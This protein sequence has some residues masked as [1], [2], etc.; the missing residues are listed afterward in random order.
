MHSGFSALRRECPMELEIRTQIEVGED[1]AKD[2][3]RVVEV[4]SGLLD[5]FGG[6]F[7][8]G[9]WSIADV[10]YTPVATRFRTWGIALADY[11]DDGRCDKY[12]QKL[13]ETPEYLEW[14]TVALA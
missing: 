5:R 4:W 3:A 2:V 8:A 11:G 13:L 12:A 7:L 10:F 14:E 1:V 9:D 6:P